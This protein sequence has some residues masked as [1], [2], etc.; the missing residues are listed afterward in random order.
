M[1]L[2]AIA[3]LNARLRPMDRGE[4]YEDALIDALNGS[5]IAAIVGGGS[6]LLPGN[7]IEF[8]CIDIDIRN[9][10]RAVPLITSTLADAGA[11]KGSFLSYT[12]QNDKRHSIRFGATVGLAIY[13]NGTD[14][15]KEVY[16]K[17]DFNYVI[18]MI[19][20]LLEGFGSCQSYWHGPAE[21]AL[22]VYGSSQAKMRRV[23][24]GFLADYPLCS[25]ARLVDLPTRIR[26]AG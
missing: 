19:D 20:E 14:L 9:V 25:K 11:P 3:T 12:D 16:A 26:E 17:S 2:A 4:R 15:P 21:T 24:R 6:Q 10:Q 7:E 5:A 13:L 1:C 22:Y 18:S 23:L 8:C